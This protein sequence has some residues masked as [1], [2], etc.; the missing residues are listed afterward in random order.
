MRSELVVNGRT[1]R[2]DEPADGRLALETVEVATCELPSTGAYR[3]C[4]CLARALVYSQIALFAC[5]T[6]FANRDSRSKRQ[7]KKKKN[8]TS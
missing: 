1:C 6:S 3:D 8:G 5:G 7:K 2:D 4:R